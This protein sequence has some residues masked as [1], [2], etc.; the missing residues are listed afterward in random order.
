MILCL[1][2]SVLGKNSA[3]LEAGGCCCSSLFEEIRSSL[4]ENTAKLSG[5]SGTGSGSPLC[6]GRIAD[7]IFV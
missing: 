6:T 4:S 7:G 2:E 3:S 5:V 1:E